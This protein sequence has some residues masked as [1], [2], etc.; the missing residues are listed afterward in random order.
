MKK[1]YLLSII[2][3]A[4]LISGCSK[5]T[6]TPTTTPTPT[7]DFSI[8]GVSYIADTKFKNNLGS[9][10]I[11]NIGKVAS[12]PN[13]YASFNIEVI[14]DSSK[15]DGGQTIS[16]NTIA[17]TSQYNLKKNIKFVGTS[18]VINDSFICYKIGTINQYKL[19]VNTTIN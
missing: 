5:T 9:K 1:T 12:F 8:N 10:V 3:I 2:S 13:D 6:T 11:I 14:G 17:F 4:L 7:G 16:S 15:I 18:I 19:Y